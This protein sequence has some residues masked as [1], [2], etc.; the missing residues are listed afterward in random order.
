[1]VELREA[2]GPSYRGTRLNMGLRWVE[3]NSAG[4]FVSKVSPEIIV[5]KVELNVYYFR[6][7]KTAVLGAIQSPATIF[8]F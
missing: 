7:D 1:M 8:G 3:G 5:I 2:V 6:W 4:I